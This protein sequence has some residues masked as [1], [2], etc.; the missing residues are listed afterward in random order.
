MTR[1]NEKILFYG[2]GIGAVYFLFAKPILNFLGITQGAGAAA[3]N[4]ALQDPANPFSV[5]YWRS[6]YYSQG[7]QPN[8]R[9]PLTAEMVSR[10]REAANYFYYGFGALGEDEESI[11]KALK[12]CKSKAEVS[13]MSNII[14]S[15]Y[16]GN[17]L[18]LMK[19]GK[20]DLP[21]G[22]LSDQELQ[23]AFK[24]VNSLPVK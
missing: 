3:Y 24:I 1:E 11:F 10:L 12:M 6:Y 14:Q 18:S 7:T 8:G 16:S 21:N 2:L 17:M 4:Q 13:I 19:F 15:T 5:T 9:L 22:G 20:T 23:N